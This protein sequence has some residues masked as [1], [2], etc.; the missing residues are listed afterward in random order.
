MLRTLLMILI[1][2]AT[3]AQAQTYKKC[4]DGQCFFDSPP[5]PKYTPRPNKANKVRVPT[6]ASAYY[7][8]RAQR[9]SVIANYNRQRLMVYRR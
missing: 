4:I 2:S 8:V 3:N 6:A 9:V 5:T 7:R 1:L